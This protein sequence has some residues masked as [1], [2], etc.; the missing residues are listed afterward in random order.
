VEGEIK[1][2]SFE[3]LFGKL[4]SLQD[5]MALIVSERKDRVIKNVIQFV[6]MAFLPV[7]F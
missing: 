7:S 3:R 4:I 6:G 2:L 5:T 1:N